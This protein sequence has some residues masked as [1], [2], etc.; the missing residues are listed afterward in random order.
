MEVTNVAEEQKSAGGW[1][2]LLL[3]LAPWVLYAVA[4]GGNHWPA[5]TVGGAILCLVYLG[6]LGRRTTVKLM[7][8]T[9][10]A[11]FVAA[12]VIMIGLR[13]AAFPVYHV[14]VIWSFFA[15][16]AWASI[17]LGKPFTYAYAREQTPPEFWENPL[18]HRINWILAFFWAGLFTVNVGFAAIGAAIGGN[19]GK[20]V[21][22]FLLPTGLL[23]FGLVF[24][25]RF[26]DR[27]MARVQI[28]PDGTISRVRTA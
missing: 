4:T 16:A 10:L 28:A 2:L 23:I 7:D 20:L 14:V 1:L 6:V 3:A 5:A 19:L 11:Y 17:A 27:Y 18:F 15:A 22:G 9:T 25:K 12:A 26:P 13:A 8:W 21:P 24:S